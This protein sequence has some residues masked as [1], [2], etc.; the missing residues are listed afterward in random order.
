MARTSDA[1]AA[2]NQ[3]RVSIDVADSEFCSGHLLVS[4]NEV[5]NGVLIYHLLGDWQVFVTRLIR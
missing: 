5:H 4:F 1:A 2:K 3:L